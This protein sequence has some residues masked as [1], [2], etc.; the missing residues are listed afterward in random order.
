M[1]HNRRDTGAFD[2]L[3]ADLDAE[4]GARMADTHKVLLENFD[5][6]VRA[7]LRVR[8]DE[9]HA[10]LSERQRWLLSLASQELRLFPAEGSRLVYLGS[11][12]KQQFLNVEWQ[13][14]DKTN[15]TFF[16]VDHPLAKCL[17]ESAAR[18]EEH[19]S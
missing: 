19:T 8:S 7:R 14:A 3:Q 15:E 10:A 17:I 13:D 18:S 5:E 2:K 16:H 9:A 6:D 12:G 1:P 4:I 11:D